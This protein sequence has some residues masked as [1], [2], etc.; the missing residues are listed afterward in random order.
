MGLRQL[1]ILLE[2]P[3]LGGWGW[4]WLV[5]MMEAGHGGCR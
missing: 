2:V 5:L 1:W 3:L 4:Q